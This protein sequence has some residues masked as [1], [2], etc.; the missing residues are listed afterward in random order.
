MELKNIKRKVKRFG[1]FGK[2]TVMVPEL[3]QYANKEITFDVIIH[4]EK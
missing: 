1:E 2:I 4:E 3:V